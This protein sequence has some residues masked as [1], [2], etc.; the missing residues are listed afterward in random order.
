MQISSTFLHRDAKLTKIIFFYQ[1]WADETGRGYIRLN[2]EF[3]F[4]STVEKKIITLQT[5][6]EHYSKT[7]QKTIWRARNNTASF[8]CASLFLGMTSPKIKHNQWP[9]L[10]TRI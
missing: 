2:K 1:I 4:P 7:L 10:S 9:S 3:W 8:S 6:T 5:H